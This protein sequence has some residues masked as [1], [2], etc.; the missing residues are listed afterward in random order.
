M[1]SQEI[2]IKALNKLVVENPQLQF[3]YKFEECDSTHCVGV[4]PTSFNKNE[5]YLEFKLGLTLLLIKKFPYELLFFVSDE[6]MHQIEE[7]TLIITGE[8]FVE[9]SKYKNLVNISNSL[10][11]VKPLLGLDVFSAIPPSS[12]CEMALDKGIVY[13]KAVNNILEKPTVEPGETNYALAA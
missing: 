4:L 12:A 9:E 6:T 3:T 8:A 7:P 1:K 10:K 2:I 13:L 11:E 5:T